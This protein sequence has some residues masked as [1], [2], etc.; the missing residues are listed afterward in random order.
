MQM[1]KDAPVCEYC[2]YDERS[3]NLPHQLPVGSIL[4][5]QYLVGRVLGQGG[6]GITYIGWDQNLSTR[7]AIKEYFPAGVVQRHVGWGTSVICATGENPEV[8]EKHKERF[9]REARTLAKFQNVP[10]V[11]QV[12]S[13]FSANGTAYIVMEYVQGITLKQYM[14]KL[15]RPMTEAEALEIMEPVLRALQKVHDEDLIHRDI[16]PDNIMLPD[17]GGIKL[18]DFGTVRYVGESGMSKSTEAVLKPGFAPIEQ[19]NSKGNLGAWT[20]V[21]A[22]CAT[23]H[24]LLTGKVPADVHVRLE[25]GESLDILRSRTDISSHMYAVLEKGMG[26]RVADRIQSITELYG[27]LYKGKQEHTAADISAAKNTEVS[28]LPRTGQSRSGKLFTGRRLPLVL[29]CGVLLL[30]LCAGLVLLRP[31]TQN[32]PVIT[33]PSETMAATE[34]WETAPQLSTVPETQKPAPDY[35]PDAWKK[36]VLMEDPSYIP[37]DVMGNSRVFGSR[38]LRKEICSITFL[39]SLDN[40]PNDSWDVSAAKDGSVLA[41]VEA[42]GSMYDLYIGADGGINASGNVCC[43]LFGGYINAEHIRFQGYF[44]TDEATSMQNM[45]YC[46]KNLQEL[47][48]TGFCTEKVTDMSGMFWKCTSL[49]RLDLS[50]FDTGCVTNMG[51]MFSDCKGLREVD[52]SGFVTVH[53]TDMVGM[54]YKCE[55]LKSLD[56][57]HFDTSNVTTMGKMFYDCT[58]L[59]SV[60][61]STWDTRKVIYMDGMFKNCPSLFDMRLGEWETDSVQNMN[62]FRDSWW[63][64]NTD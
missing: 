60:D 36:N 10:E 41:W 24:Y 46:S 3:A 12:R 20:D 54:F 40:V 45:F 1:K 62:D 5:N 31:K 34:N 7:V 64:Q 6:F 59:I 2:G 4:G 48:M 33:E 38:I 15:G 39:D 11:V 32:I 19:Y 50:R 47:D 27:L 51:A 44:H 63:E 57:R 61:L 9:L 56:L 17:A 30:G 13:F 58:N 18:I 26:I 42:N 53:V 49:Q 29:A 28:A 22:I 23:F 14:K 55:S 37:E 8:Y 35:P 43:T 21:Y 25:E 52:T 16:S